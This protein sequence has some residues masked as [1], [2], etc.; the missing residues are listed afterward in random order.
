LF[1]KDKARL[2]SA[3]A[4]TGHYTIP[5]TVTSIDQAAFSEN[6]TSVTV[7]ATT[8]PIMGSAV[9]GGSS[10]PYVQSITV[11]K[12]CA[13]AYKTAEGWSNYADKIVEAS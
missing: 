5:A 12:G 10:S 9:F 2:I 8:P 7:L 11:P 13:E 4:V 6:I 3:G 1:T